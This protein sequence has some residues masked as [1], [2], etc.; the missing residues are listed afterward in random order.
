MI[1]YSPNIAIC[2]ELPEEADK[3][4]IYFSLQTNKSYM[5]CDGWV[6]IGRDPTLEIV[7]NKVENKEHV[8][9]KRSYANCPCCG[10]PVRDSDTC[11]YC[12]V[13]YPDI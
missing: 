13:L 9:H 10:A 4:T 2:L 5:F 8:K 11:A 6:E 3:G 12:G 7:Q 1:N